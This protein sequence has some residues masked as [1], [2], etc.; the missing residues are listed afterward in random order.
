MPNLAGMSRAAA[1]AAL[2]AAG[3]FY[4]TKGPGAGTT[5][6]THVVSTVPAAGSTVPYMSTVILNVA[7]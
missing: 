5:K 3:L 1:N 6:W 2:K 4:S 7:E